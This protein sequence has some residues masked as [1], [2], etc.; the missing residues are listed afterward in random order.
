ML[1]S[2]CLPAAG[3]VLFA[4]LFAQGPG[5]QTPPAGGGTTGGGIGTTPSTP[6][7]TPTPSTPTRPNQPGLDDLNTIQRVIFISGKVMMD[8]GSPLPSNIAVQKVCGGINPQTMA[9]TDAKGHFNFQW[10]QPNSGFADASESTFGNIPGMSGRRANSISTDA[11]NSGGRINGCEVQV[12]VPGYRGNSIQIFNHTS[13][14][15]PDIG[16]IVLHRLGNVEGLSVSAT[17]MGASKDAKKAFDRGLQAQLKNKNDEAAKDFEKATELYPK[18]ADAWYNLGKVRAR[19][20]QDEP[21]RAAL[22]KAL[23]ADPKL[24]GP[25]VEL[26]MLAAGEEKWEDAQKYLDRANHLDPVDFPQAWYVQ[27]VAE[28]NIGNLEAAEK[29]AREARKLDSRHANPRTG[30]L[31]GVILAEM[32]DFSGAV[33]EFKSYL[34]AAPNAPDAAQVQSKVDELSKF[35][36]PR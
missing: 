17:G 28:Y 27:A 20:K 5:G 3:L 34:K 14:D 21:A 35:I 13:L 18:Y 25:Y 30:Y 32:R 7:R 1:R 2:L 11:M 19:L 23:E 15:N 26:G 8:D 4:A 9:Y 24:V 12:N 31:L 29:C 33:D 6:G 16:T 36:G 22:Q 10:D